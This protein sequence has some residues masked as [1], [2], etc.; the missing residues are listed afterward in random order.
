MVEGV[1]RGNLQERMSHL[2][3]KRKMTNSLLPFR[4][5][6][7]ERSETQSGPLDGMASLFPIPGVY[8]AGWYKGLPVYSTLRSR[9]LLRYNACG[10]HDYRRTRARA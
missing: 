7:K 4:D 6:W 8:E 9:S 1:V 5:A 3:Q 10:L 2:L